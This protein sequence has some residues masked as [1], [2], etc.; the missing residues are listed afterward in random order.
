MNAIQLII[1]NLE[2]VR[3]RSVKLWSGIPVDFL[4]WKP[5]EGAMSCI[6]MIRHVLESEHYYHMALINGGSLSEYETPFAGKPY[7]S[8]ENELELAW[9]FR[10]SFLEYVSELNEESLSAVKIDRSDVGYV[11][12]MGDMLMRIA[13]HESVHAGQLLDYLRTAGSTRENLWD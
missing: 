9:P 3:R 1:L 8:V 6:E 5:D 13:Y 4:H 2:E 7:I 10:K 12:E 11:R